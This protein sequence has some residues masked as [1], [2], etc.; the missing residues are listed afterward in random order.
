MYILWHCKFHTLRHIYVGQSRTLAYEDKSVNK[1]TQSSRSPRFHEMLIRTNMSE[2]VQL[3][4]THTKTDAICIPPWQ[5]LQCPWCGHWTT[6]DRSTCRL[7]L[8]RRIQL[9]KRQC[10]KIRSHRDPRTFIIGFLCTTK[11]QSPTGIRWLSNPTWNLTT[12][13]G[14]ILVLVFSWNFT[15]FMLIQIFTFQFLFQFPLH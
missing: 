11:Y 15:Y 5:Q 13:S 10:L 1:D 2:Y 8:T 6:D 4:R 7:I 9:K 14:G 3:V 12:C